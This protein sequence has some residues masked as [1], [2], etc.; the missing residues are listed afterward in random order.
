MFKIGK[1]SKVKEIKGKFEKKLPDDLST[2]KIFKCDINR[3]K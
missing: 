3:R 1:K 2:Q